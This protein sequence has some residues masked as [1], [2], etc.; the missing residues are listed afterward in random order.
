MTFVIAAITVVVMVVVAIVVLVVAVIA[1]VV[2]WF[3]VILSDGTRG[4]NTAT[5][6]CVPHTLHEGFAQSVDFFG[7]IRTKGCGNSGSVIHPPFQFE[8]AYEF[9]AVSLGATLCDLVSANVGFV[10]IVHEINGE[11]DHEIALLLIVV[12]IVEPIVEIGLC[13]EPQHGV[14]SI[15]YPKALFP[16]LHDNCPER[17]PREHES[18]LAHEFGLG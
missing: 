14:G 4:S 16:F 9:V 12:G 6:G 18:F 17:D 13:P 15:L 2:V 5:Q 7:I 3:G 11:F 1:V 10:E 8:L